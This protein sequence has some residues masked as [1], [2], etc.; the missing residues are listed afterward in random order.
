MKNIYKIFIYI[1]LFIILF[2]VFYWILDYFLTD[3]F[4]AN[5]WC[6]VDQY[7]IDCFE[8]VIKSMVYALGLSLTLSVFFAV[9]IWKKIIKF[10]FDKK[11]F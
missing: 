11:Q 6:I 8:A 7:G 1:A 3:F 2:F 4:V 10:F 9:F 5:W